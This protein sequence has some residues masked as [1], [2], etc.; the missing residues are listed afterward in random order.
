MRAEAKLK[1]LQAASLAILGAVFI[2]LLWNVYDI[3]NLQG[4]VET[5]EVKQQA[6]AADSAEIIELELQIDASAAEIEGLQTEISDM[7]KSLEAERASTD[8]LREDLKRAVKEL[9]EATG[10]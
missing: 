1:L 8:M 2:C 4:Q 10:Q 6:G 5:L 9:R 7:R 3:S